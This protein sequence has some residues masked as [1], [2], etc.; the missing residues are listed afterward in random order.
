MATTTPLK[1]K[2][3]PSDTETKIPKPFILRRLHSLLGLWLVLYLLEHL[4]V[5]S[6]AAFFIQ[7][8]GSTFIRLVNALED[9]PYLPVIE[10]VFLGLPFLIHMVW[11][12][13]YL[14]TAKLNAHPTDGS[15]PQLPQYKRNK[16]YSWQRIT[17]YLLLPAII[18]HVLQMR[19]YERPL[20]AIKSLQ[21]HYMVRLKEDKGLSGV[22]NILGASIYTSQDLESMQRETPSQE[23]KKW[24]DVANQRVPRAGEVLVVTPNAGSAYFLALREIFKNPLMVILYSLFVVAACYHAFNGLWTAMIVWGLTL[25]RRSQKRMRTFSNVLMALTIFLGLLSAWGVYWT[26]QFQI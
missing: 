15:K 18:L 19:F 13:L 4:L 7:D 21:P 11:G 2:T 14:R 1:E 10:L 20:L 12:V 24:F 8:E 26:T 22:T 25:T 3:F 5:N 9:L 16:A 17:S 23:E 6:Q